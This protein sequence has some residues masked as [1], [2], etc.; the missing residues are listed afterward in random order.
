VSEEKRRA[1]ELA[2]RRVLEEEPEMLGV[3]SGTTVALFIRE[4]AKRG[5]KG[6]AVSTSI[7]T[8]LILKKYGFKVVELMIVDEVD[9]SVDGADEISEN[10]Y[11]IKGG[12]AAMLREKVMAIISKHKIYIA[13]SSKYVKKTCERG[14]PIPA[15]VVPHSLPAVVKDLNRL[16]VGWR[17][18]EGKGKLGPIV[19]DNGNIIIDLNC[20]EALPMIGEIERLTGIAAVGLFTPD[21]VDEV[22]IGNEIIYR[23]G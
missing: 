9:M 17:Y 2:A 14:V 20:K 3:G 19:T 22:I 7:D 5:F 16:G 12:G 4:L 6:I 10:L 11:L 18:R 1:A 23:K 13:D 15:E 21:L 8:S